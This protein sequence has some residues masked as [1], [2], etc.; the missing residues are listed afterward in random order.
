MDL[1]IQL[2][3]PLL[4]LAVAFGSGYG[5]REYVARRGTLPRAKNSTTNI[6]TFV[7]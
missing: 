7:N 5:V 1:I 6:P 4:L 3:P 2:A